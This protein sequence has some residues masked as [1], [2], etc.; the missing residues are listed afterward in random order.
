MSAR[1]TCLLT[2]ALA[3]LASS[4]LPAGAAADIVPQRGIAG[5]ALNMTQAQVREV[6]GEPRGT[7]R[8][9]NDFGPFTLWTYRDRVTVGFQGD[10][11]VT[12][13]DTTGRRERTSRGVGVGSSERY[14]RR[15]VRGA[16]CRTQYGSRFCRV[17][18][19]L[20]RRRVTS[21]L[22]E[23]NRVTRVGIGFVID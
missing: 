10:D 4:L 22:I 5:I 23:R 14:V 8:G 9:S 15:R 3:V 18:R 1:R 2:A 7:E 13:V 16:R 12:S 20:P 19:L 6:A 17:G 21:F 11:R